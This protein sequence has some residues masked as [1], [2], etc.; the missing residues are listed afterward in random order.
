MKFSL[1]PVESLSVPYG[2]ENSGLQA[3]KIICAFLVVVIHTIGCMSHW[4]FGLTRVAV[5]LFFMVTGF[6]IPDA[7]GLITTR[8][9]KRMIIKLLWITI[10]AQLFYMAFYA[11]HSLVVDHAPPVD[12]WSIRAW[13]YNIVMGDKFGGHLWYL[14]SC[15][16]ALIVIWIA[17][18]ARC[19]RL[20]VWFIPVGLAVN[21]L[22][23]SY[24]G[25]LGIGMTH[26]VVCRGVLSTALPCIMTGVVMRRMPLPRL[27]P[28]LV[29][30]V[31]VCAALMLAEDN[32]V[33]IFNGDMIVMTMPLS[34]LIFIMFV[35]MPVS[36]PLAFA[37][38][39]YATGIYIFHLAVMGV[40][41]HIDGLEMHPALSVVT[42]ALTLSI[43]VAWRAISRTLT[44]KRAQTA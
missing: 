16:Q 38:K 20:L 1:K 27:S 9:I 13:I 28:S 44:I 15:L 19:E 11:V 3:L 10:G 39:T 42:F 43:L 4:A 18:R 29:V 41:K 40:V 34:I 35:G 25:L 30:A 32:F 7:S 31:V 6:F 37:G 33:K 12:L 5:P 2:S 17:T 24:A 36:A 8:R 22:F 21:L 26:H 14:T 23:G